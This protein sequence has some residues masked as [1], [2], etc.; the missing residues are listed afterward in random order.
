[1]WD[2][3][4]D[5]FKKCETISS[6]VCN[7]VHSLFSW[8]WKPAGSYKWIME[9]SWGAYC[10]ESHFKVDKYW[11]KSWCGNY[12]SQTDTE[13]EGSPSDWWSL[14]FCCI[15]N[16]IPW[17]HNMPILILGH[18]ILEI[19]R[20]LP[21]YLGEGHSSGSHWVLQTKEWAKRLVRN[22]SEQAKLSEL[23]RLSLFVTQTK[24]RIINIQVKTKVLK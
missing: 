22:N 12:C 9:G 21:V 18:Q 3:D 24:L 11:N 4:K 14:D 15:N 13:A 16:H 5:A 2:V 20:S 23:S 8:C 19:L 17:D 1:M 10:L 6:T 7:W